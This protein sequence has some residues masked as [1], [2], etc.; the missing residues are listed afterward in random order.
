MSYVHTTVIQQGGHAYTETRRSKARYGACVVST[1]MSEALS[2]IDLRRA[3]LESELYDLQTSLGAL[4]VLTAKTPE[5]VRAALQE[6]RQA[7]AAAVEQM[8]RERTDYQRMYAPLTGYEV[9][10]RLG[11][12]GLA[13]LT[14]G[15]LSEMSRIAR[16]I[17]QHRG[18]LASLPKLVLG[19]QRVVSW[20]ATERLADKAARALSAKRAGYRSE[21]RTL[22]RGEIKLREVQVRGPRDSAVP[23]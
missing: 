22:A 20:H 10:A 23:S 17:E 5:E 12:M 7:R 8:E 13:D 21:V 4:M 15:N 11:A 3:Q 19:N 14:N 18:A 2:R 1:V 9:E 16:E 6:R